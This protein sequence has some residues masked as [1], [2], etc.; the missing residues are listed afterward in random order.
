[1]S[2]GG[3][4]KFLYLKETRPA[5]MPEPGQPVINNN[6]AR[7][8]YVSSSEK[9]MAEYCKLLGLDKEPFSMTPDPEFFY[10]TKGHGN[11]INRLEISLRLNRGLNVIIGGIGTGKTTLSRLLLN[12]FNESGSDYSFFLILDPTWKDN[13]QFLSHLKKLF[14]IPDEGND[15]VDMV[16]QIEHFLI[17]YTLNFKKRVI[18]MID[19][20]Q[21]MG[22]E[23]VEIVRT[24]LN[25]ET[26]NT[27][28]IQVII[29]AQPEFQDL[30]DSMENFRDRIAFAYTIPPMDKIDTLCFIDHRLKIAGLKNG[31]QLFNAKAKE[32][33]F[34]YTKGYPRKIVVACHA[35][36]IDMLTLNKDQVDSDLVFQ[37]IKSGGPF[38]V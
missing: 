12:R 34:D 6:I 1:M 37:L 28:L 19:E 7:Y 9:A 3:K 11:C 32:L 15:P 2:I 30:L 29:F 33:L 35:L 17:D 14:E 22:P 8:N 18:L 16:N 36:I 23:Q 13:E 4:T 31:R 20:G 26:N 24:L 38:Y 5:G 21:K 10:Q 27:K 25:F